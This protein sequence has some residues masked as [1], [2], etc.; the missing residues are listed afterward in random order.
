MAGRRVA[1]ERARQVRL[2]Q[3]CNPTTPRRGHG[4]SCPLAN[5]ATWLARISGPVHLRESP[6][7]HSASPRLCFVLAVAAATRF[8]RELD[9]MSEQSEGKA[10]TVDDSGGGGS[11][12][13]YARVLSSPTDDGQAIEIGPNWFASVMGT[14]ILANAAAS[15]PLISDH[16][17]GFALAA[18]LLASTMLIGLIIAVT[19]Q[20]VARPHVVEKHTSDPMMA[21]FFGA[22]PMALMTVGGGT[23]LVGQPI[24]GAELA[25]QIAWFLWALGTIG[26]LA[27]AVTVPYRLFT[28]F[29]V[30]RDAA[31]G[32]W[33]MPVVPPMVSAAIG[34]ML[35]P[36][37]PEGALRATMLYGC[38]A[39]FGLSLI[40]ALVIISMIWSRLAHYGTSGSAR[41]P[42]LW[43][44]L[45]PLGQSITAAGSL[46][47]IAHTA[48]DPQLARAMDL[49]AVLYGVPVWGFALLWATLAACLT[50]RARRRNM[51]FALTWWSFTFP[52]GTCV[53]GTSQLALHTELP[54][55]E[56]A[57]PLAYFGL[58]AAWLIAAVGTTRGIWHG[59]LLRPPPSAG[60]IVSSKD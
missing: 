37:T 7:K 60:P 32:G 1:N 39:M 34:A 53:T 48:V 43:I 18:W 38:Y 20:W 12:S 13:K 19:I 10:T 58:L 35:I 8:Y 27:T 51:P 4:S 50:L 44:V 28:H 6:S 49:F 15:L 22:P 25:V 31:F 54:A 46:G 45:G 29:E 2:G 30:G 59:T 42:T 14:G 57:A 47:H 33:L 24:L 16:L 52:V 21:Q 5:V 56:W 23:L 36:H 3:R 41:V 40:S 9:T 11:W 17:H 55:F 26:G